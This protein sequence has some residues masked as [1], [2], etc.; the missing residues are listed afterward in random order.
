[1]K[2]SGASFKV[3]IGASVKVGAGLLELFV[4]LFLDQAFIS[5]YTGVTLSVNRPTKYVSNPIIGSSQVDSW[6]AG[7]AFT[8]NSIAYNQSLGIYESW[9][10]AIVGHYDDTS[11]AYLTSVDGV[12]FIKP[13]LGLVSYGE[14]TNNNIALINWEDGDSLNFIPNGV[15]Y[16]PDNEASQVYLC[17]ASGNIDVESTYGFNIFKSSDGKTWSFLK[18]IMSYATYNTLYGTGA[19]EPNELFKRND[20]RYV[21]YFGT[22]HAAQMR[23]RGAFLSDS[24]DLTGSWTHQGVVC[25][26]TAPTDQKYIIRSTAIGELYL[27]WVCTYNSVADTV[28]YIELYVSRDG[29]SLTKIDAAWITKGTSGVDWDGRRI[30]PCNG[31]NL[32]FRN[33]NE[34]NFYYNGADTGHTVPAVV[35]FGMVTIPYRRIGQ[36]GGTGNLTTTELTT[37]EFMRINCNGSGGYVKIEL[38]DPNTDAV[39]TGYTKENCD[40]IITDVYE[41]TV[42]WGGSRELPAGNF[43]A[44]FYLSNAFLY[45][46]S[47]MN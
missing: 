5:T 35:Y 24:T 20:G 42:T 18:L 47:L 46:Y 17:E 28:P 45:S 14:N 7:C 10:H 34:W 16:F 37:A 13:N 25:S 43:K 3:N 33:G 8:M 40:S 31:G 36:V 27:H 26:A 30:Y 1:M 41:N 23:N 44:K 22:N 2:F 19:C 11:L 9:Y 6:D 21:A 38:L 29:I 15:T 39:L 12:T 32:L 4:E